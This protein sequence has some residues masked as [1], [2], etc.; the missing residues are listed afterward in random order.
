M[1]KTVWQNCVAE[2]SYLSYKT[3]ANPFSDVEVDVVFTDPAGQTQ[4]VPAF[5]AGENTWTIRYASPVLGKHE[6]QTVC[7][8]TAN[9]NLHGQEGVL[10]V[11]PYE[12]TNPLLKHGPLRVASSRRH[13]EHRDGTPFFWLGD[14]WWM[15][16]CSKLRWPEDFRELTADRVT[17]GF[18][19]IQIVAGLY[20]DMEPFDPRSVNE[21]GYPWERDWSRI[22][23]AYFD[24]ADQRIAHLVRAG[25][26][27][28]IVGSWG[29]Y[30]K[31]AGEAVLRKHWRNLIARYGAYPVVWCA[32]GEACAPFYLDF[33]AGSEEEYEAQTRAA[34][35]KITRS[36]REMDPYQHPVTIH[37]RTKGHE[38]VEDLSL[39]DMNWLQPG[40]PGYRA[41]RSTINLLIDALALEPKMPVIVDEVNYEG[42]T[43]TCNA[44]QQRFLFWSCMLSGAAGHTYGANGL[45]QMNTLESPHGPSPQGTSWGD[46]PWNEAYR[47]PGSAQLGL[48]K[49]LLER[50]PWWQFESH[51]EWI[52]PHQTPKRRVSCY[53]AGIP[54]EVRVIYIPVEERY[55]LID[56]GKVRV[57]GLEPNATYHGLYCSPIT[58]KEYA[59]GEVSGDVEGGWSVPRAPTYQDWVLVLERKR[60]T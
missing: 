59:L 26:V 33:P 23:P 28:V 12:G 16:L 27:P 52:E 44:D 10:E 50:Y 41:F 30:M 39:L 13:L 1:P 21:A 43:G 24:M 4:R 5:W 9:S 29:Y 58:G 17:K 60:S 48:G 8:D 49:R 51:P 45:W 38:E 35:T 37:P 31:F 2:W 18:S 22:N 57:L 40:H 6:Y 55:N 11:L 56:F 46:T 19:A 25:L 3:Y 54:E 36:I 53:A 20:P 47:L 42:I 34:W 14:T 32:A 7:S 15:A